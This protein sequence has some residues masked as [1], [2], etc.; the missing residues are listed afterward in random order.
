MN[1]KQYPAANRCRAASHLL[2]AFRF[3]GYIGIKTPVQVIRFVLEYYGGITRHGFFSF[4]KGLAVAIAEGYFGR[5]CN[6]PPHSRN[7][8][9]PLDSR[10]FVPGVKNN[11]RID[12]YFKRLALFVETLYR[13]YPAQYPYLRCGNSHTF[14]I[15][16]I[17]SGQ[18]AVYEKGEIG[19]REHLF[20]N[21]SRFAAQ[22]YRIGR[23]IDGVQT[24]Y[25][26]PA[27][28]DYQQFIFRKHS[29]YRFTPRERTHC[30]EK[31]T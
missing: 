29:G 22:Q 21:R 19:R 8:Q 26:R 17:Y 30:T 16:V 6:T 7:R 2:H 13:N 1:R 12:I 3:R 28:T 14:I 31:Y 5:P 10:Y 20:L 25:A 23:V 11:L 24:H 4:F 15:G 9:A 18:H 27:G